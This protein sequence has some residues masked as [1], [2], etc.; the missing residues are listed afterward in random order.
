LV[1]SGVYDKVEMVT[2][3]LNR[4]TYK[5]TFQ[6]RDTS[7][8]TKSKEHVVKGIVAGGKITVDLRSTEMAAI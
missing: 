7:D 5:Y 3:N 1:K 8:S 6:L 2:P 4:G